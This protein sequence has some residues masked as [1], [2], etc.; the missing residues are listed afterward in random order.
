M[1]STI[2]NANMPLIVVSGPSGSGKSTL[3][4]MLFKK[5]PDKFGFSV[6]HTTRKPREGEINGVHYHFISPEKMK[7]EIEKGRFL[8]T[9]CFSGNTYGTSYEAVENVFKYGKVCVLDIEM[10]GVKQVKRKPGLDLVLI[11]IKP[12]SM[13]ILEHRL[14]NRGT[15]SEDSLHRRL[16]VVREEIRFGETDGNFDTVII[17]DDMM[18]AYN[19]LE[20][21]VTCELSKRNIHLGEPIS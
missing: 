10:E 21:F 7:E 18:S 12:P 9:A 11:F 17:N 6:S 19:Q 8:E 4:Q 13:D 14:R 1:V 3:L 5:F 15:E 2:V 20:E 16:S